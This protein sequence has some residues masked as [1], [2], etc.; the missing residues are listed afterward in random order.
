MPQLVA[1]VATYLAAQGLGLTVGSTGNLFPVPF[2]PSAPQ[3]A[4]CLREY[5]G[6][7]AIRNFGASLAAPVCEVRRFQVLTRDVANNFGTAQT[8][9]QNISNQLDSIGDT[10]LSAVR[11]LNIVALGPPRYLGEDENGRHEFA[12]NFEAF[13]ARTSG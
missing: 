5:G 13:R 3:A 4:V 10:T 12:Q 2:P 9:A 1:E 11:Y 6:G 8:L 7:P